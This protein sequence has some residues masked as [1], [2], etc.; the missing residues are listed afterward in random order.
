MALGKFPL[1]I[2][3]FISYNLTRING[4]VPKPG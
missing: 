4:A 1:D 3:L 2:S